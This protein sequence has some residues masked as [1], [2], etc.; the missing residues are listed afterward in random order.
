MI[1]STRHKGL[2]RLHQQDDPR[3]VIR[4]H[5]VKL[6]DILARLDAASAAADMDMP[7]FRLHA[8]KGDRK[9]FWA[10]TVRANLRVIFRLDEGDDALGVTRATLSELVN[11][12]RR[13]S[14]EMDVRLSKAFGGSAQ[15]WLTQ[16]AQ[17]DLAHV[18]VDRVKVKRLQLA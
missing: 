5:V 15:S 1:V 2:K 16:Q 18:R 14:P 10:V 13:I 7:G 3:G 12:K 11:E 9:G 17:Y 8:L 4:D 6:R